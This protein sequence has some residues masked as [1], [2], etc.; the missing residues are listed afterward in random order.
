MAWALQ[1]MCNQ[2][3][4]HMPFSNYYEKISSGMYLPCGH[5]ALSKIARFIHDDVIKWKHFPCYRLFVEVNHQLPVDSP[6]KGQWCQALIFLCSPSG[7]MVEKTIETRVIWDVIAL[8]M[9][10]LWCFAGKYTRCTCIEFAYLYM[11]PVISVTWGH[12]YVCLSVIEV[13]F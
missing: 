1:C 13:T 9:T 8:I 4:H 10:S 2:C 7:Q 5:N 3:A 11:Q 6:H 12:L